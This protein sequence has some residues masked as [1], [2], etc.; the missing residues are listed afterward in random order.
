MRQQSLNQPGSVIK[1]EGIKQITLTVEQAAPPLGQ[2]YIYYFAC[3]LVTNVF[4][5]I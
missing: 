2:Q 1:L 5:H 4:Q 3:T